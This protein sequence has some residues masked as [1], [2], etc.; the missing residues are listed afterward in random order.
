LQSSSSKANK[1]QTRRAIQY[2]TSGKIKE[3][4][5]F[6][7]AGMGAVGAVTS[8]LKGDLGGVFSS[9][10]GVGKKIMNSNSGAADRAKQMNTSPA[11]KL[12]FILGL[13]TD[14]SV[15]LHSAADRSFLLCNR[16][17]LLERMQG[18]PNF[19]RCYRG[20]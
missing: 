13:K 3:P 10:T 1:P 5:L 6:K 18:C 4:N 19:C 16:R 11:G 20:W 8:Y 17:H 7:D 15:R 2:D 12:P 14:G 9:L